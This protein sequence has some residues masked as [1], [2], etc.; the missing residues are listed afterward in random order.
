MTY[1][2]LLDFLGFLAIFFDPHAVLNVFNSKMSI[3]V[4]VVVV[5]VGLFKRRSN[6]EN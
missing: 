3:K 1:I 5:I 2:D 6:F 4:V